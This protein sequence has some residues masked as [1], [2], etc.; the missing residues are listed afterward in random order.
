MKN[1]YLAGKSIY[2][3]SPEEKDVYGDWY[4]WF[5][6]QEITEFLNHYLPNSIEKQKDFYEQTKNSENKLVL[7]ICDKK[8]DKHI[9]V[10]GLDSIN[11]INRS[12]NLS[13]II[14]DKRYQKGPYVI[15]A[16]SLLIECAF[17][18]LNLKNLRSYFNE[19]NIKSEKL[20]QLFKFEFIGKFKKITY[21][22]GHYYDDIICQLS[23]QKWLK[24]NKQ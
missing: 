8:N 7:S 13:I 19:K 18:N 3:R 1:V 6:D 24:Y 10:C 16:F 2:L 4:Q 12:A 17:I 11:W 14:G 5:S 21:V 22:N 20:H 9:G 23:R 15:E